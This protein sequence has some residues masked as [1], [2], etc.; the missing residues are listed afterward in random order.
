MS[1]THG[2]TVLHH[3]YQRCWGLQYGARHESMSREVVTIMTAEVTG[4]A[5]AVDYYSDCCY[6]ADGWCDGE[7][8]AAN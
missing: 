3:Y 2:K 5:D 1:L 8:K 7:R 4:A 6:D